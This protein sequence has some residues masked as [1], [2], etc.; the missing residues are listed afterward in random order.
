MY[1]RLIK[2][3]IPIYKGK[4][5][6]I[7]KGALLYYSPKSMNPRGSEPSWDFSKLKEIKIK[8]IASNNFRFYKYK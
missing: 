2:A 7:T 4:K 8:G 3:V 1:E 5:K 6:D